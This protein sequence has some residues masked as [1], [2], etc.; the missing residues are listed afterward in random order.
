MGADVG[1][2]PLADCRSTLFLPCKRHVVAGVFWWVKVEAAI[3]SDGGF[4]SNTMF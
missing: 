4:G 1:A 3:L 2:P